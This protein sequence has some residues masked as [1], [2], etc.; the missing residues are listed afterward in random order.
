[1]WAHVC[2]F[3]LYVYSNRSLTSVSL[4]LRDNQKLEEKLLVYSRGWE[5]HMSFNIIQSQAAFSSCLFHGHVAVLG[6]VW[7]WTNLFPWIK[8]NVQRV[9]PC[10]LTVLEHRFTYS[11]LVGTQAQFSPASGLE[12]FR[13]KGFSPS[14]SYS[15]KGQ[16]HQNCMPI[17]PAG[18]N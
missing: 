10:E 16:C 5:S 15:V 4:L 11:R 14:L 7:N 17:W 6:S 18:I 8:R 1:M 13:Q 3:L 12:T 9:A 2:L